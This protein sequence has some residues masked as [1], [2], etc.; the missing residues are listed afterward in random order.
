MEKVSSYVFFVLLLTFLGGPKAFA[1]KAKVRNSL[2]FKGQQRSLIEWE[3]SS[4]KWLDF[5]VWKAERINK[6]NNPDWEILAKNR[7]LRENMGRVIKCIGECLLHRGLKFSNADYRSGVKE[8]D[9]LTTGKDSY[10]WI[11]LLDGTLV[12]LS[13]NSSISFKEINIGIDDIFLHARMNYGNILWLPRDPRL[14]KESNLRETDSLFLPLDLLDANME[15]ENNDYTEK[16]LYSALRVPENNWIHSKKLNQLINE[17]NLI[18]DYKPTYSFLIMPNGSVFGANL[19]ME[20][21]VL[22]GGP[23][24]IKKRDQNQQR[25]KVGEIPDVD[26]EL[27]TPSLFYYR[28]FQNRQVTQLENGFWYMVTKDGMGLGKSQVKNGPEYAMGEFITRRVTSLLIARELMLRKYSTFIFEDIIDS[29]E[30]AQK[31]GFRLWGKL[32]SKPLEDMG[33]RIEFLI[34][35]TRRIETTNLIERDKYKTRLKQR[36]LKITEMAFSKAFYKKALDH[37]FLNEQGRS[38]Q[39]SDR[40]ILNSTKHP[41]WK[42]FQNKR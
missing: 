24:F 36:G 8:G 5:E 27:E 15:I 32:V 33:K 42:K 12:R 3:K 21:V 37:Y 10:I 18:I 17:N 23:S 29:V 14:V 31:Y 22:D 26:A 11:F 30:F 38:K 19:Q 6:E 34:E 25:L 2:F 16:N 39:R 35:Y 20:F 41:F 9:E 4:E 28:G 13:P 40:E 1:Q 7:L